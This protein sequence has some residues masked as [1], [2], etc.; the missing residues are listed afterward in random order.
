MAGLIILGALAALL[1]LFLFRRP[2]AAVLRLAGRTAL[3]LA[4]LAAVTPLEQLAGISLG[5]NL[6]NAAVVGILGLPGFGLL[7]MLNWLVG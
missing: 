4:V 2:L 1:V 6:W 5:V 3:G 7:L